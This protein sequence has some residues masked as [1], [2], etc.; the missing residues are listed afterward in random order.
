MNGEKT[1]A[2]LATSGTG[3]WRNTAVA[4]LTAIVGL[5]AGAAQAALTP[6]YRFYHLDAGRHFYTASESEKAK[7][8]T[9]YPRFAYEGVAFYAYS[10]QEAGTVPVHRFYHLL[11]GSHVY[12][13]SESEKQTILTNYPVYAYEGIAYYAQPSA[14]GDG[15]AL[16]R[17]YNTKLGTHFFTTSQSEA[18]NATA[19]WP[20]FV[21]E[22][23]IYYVRST[24]GPSANV[25]PTVSLTTT[26]TSGKVGD[27]I[28]L[29]A[30]ANDSDG[31]VVK[32][33]YYKD[34]DKIGE[35]TSAPHLLSY[36]LADAGT[37]TFSAIAT[38]NGGMVAASNTIVANVTGSGGGGGGGGGMNAAPT[39]FIS[40]G[41]TSLVP[42][43]S[44]EVTAS[45][46][47]SDGSIAKVEFYSGTTL[48]S[49]DGYAP[50]T[51]T[52]T[53]NTNGT[54]AITAIAYDNLGAT[55]TSNA[56]NI[57]VSGTANAA[58]TVTLA[59]AANA[60]A[61]GG[62]TVLTATA[63]D[64]DGT[65]TKVDFYD[66][67]TLISSDTSAPYN[68][69]FTSTTAGT[70]ALR[71]VAFDNMGAST[72]SAT[73]NVTVAAVGSN[74][75]PS[76]TITAATNAVV[77]GGTVAI[78]ATASDSDGTI[79]KVEFY[80]GTTLVNN[81]TTAP[82][83]FNF[84]STT[85]GTHSITARAYDDKGATTNSAPVVVTVTA[86]PGSDLPRITLSAS[87]TLVAPGA[88]VTL[89][90]TATATATGATVAMVSFYMDGVKLAD[91]TV[92][93]YTYV[94]TVPAGSHSVYAV[95]RDSLGKTN[96]TLTQTIVGQTAPAIATTSPDVWRLL[97]QATFGA[98]QAEA[99]RVVALG[100]PGWIDDQFTKP[101]SGYPDTKY[102]KIQLTTSPDCTTSMPGG[103]T[104]PTNSPESMCSR[105]HLSLAMVQRDFFTNA[106]Y[107]SDQ[108]RQRVAWAL[109]Q[110]V[111]TSATE[112]DLS[113]AHV[114]SRYQSIMFDEAFGNYQ[115]LLSKVTYNP[116]MGN[117][118]DM[119]NN[120]RPAGTRVPNENYARE[121]MQLFSIGLVELN[122]DGTL[123]LDAQG[124]PI[125]TYGQA[126]IAE[127]ARVFTGYTY[128]SAANPA[129]PATAK[130]GRYYGAPMVP[131][132]TT[133]NAGHD[134]LAKTLL[135][136]TVLP[137]GQ[138]GQQ[139]I[140]AAVLNVFMHPNT[141]PFVSKQLIQRLVTGNPS[142]AYVRRIAAV[143]ENN[144]AGVRGDL[145][146]VVRAILLDSE[147][148]GGTKTAADYGT[149]KEPVLVITGL[150]R[151]LSGV[152][153]GAQL[154]TQAS[155]LG[156][157]PYFSPTV[158]NYFPPDATIPG[159]AIL[160]PEFAIHTTN[161]AVGRANLIYRMVYQGF[162][163]DPNIIDSGGTRLF[164]DQF[165]ALATDP[166]A[167]VAQ[168]NKVLAGGQFPV[169]LEPTIATAVS[170]VTLSA[171]PTADQKLNRIR[172]A[173]YLMASS[174]DYQVQR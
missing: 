162:A 95:V 133:A 76:V 62:S 65:I 161:S 113:Y 37:F 136:G 156:Q 163:A 29:S 102:N 87:N 128:S 150:L 171:T 167:L 108:L 124:K 53:T 8:I 141:P 118:L 134:P 77:A 7:V 91:D 2:K 44:T 43:G 69:T 9:A 33:E 36:T 47:D 116:A 153:D 139:D 152:T 170:A 109:S 19:A 111:V 14:G 160:A 147:A 21:L 42:G 88:S 145:R 68:H 57:V 38:D 112:G 146:A 174:Y 30:T 99:A 31:T 166:A 28:K 122:D 63:A 97:N 110:I 120:D 172:M 79:A 148:R 130:Q 159:T 16:Y 140:D 84:S 126:E 24:G 93:P 132:P 96:Q 64:T 10:T 1:M 119:V 106:V 80:D 4:L 12:T 60:I 169:A 125:P 83:G 114:M 54:Y 94:V 52:F 45:A 135:N 158:F 86:V 3:K 115:D 78:A 50:F 168:V 173:V 58:P 67:S 5:T 48:L 103:G 20:W 66:G 105:D 49:V 144:G 59:A 137:A 74:A 100:I 70:H 41:T 157:N 138:T 15:V 82:Y 149:L 89:T 26:A 165:D 81:D 17:L 154:A 90:G 6:V 71:A 142:P 129:G 121:I 13:A 39:V 56:V 143:F 35:T 27:V 23:A 61:N 101:V 40:A 85:V 72:T 34:A 104:Y 73:V 25:A 51:H 92:T 55:G 155:N 11:N 127:F 46:T 117:Y 131:Y 18:N 164:L 98:S 123:L 22:G 107:A 75:P 151:A 32:V